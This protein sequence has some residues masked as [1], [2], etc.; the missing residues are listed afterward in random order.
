M[1]RRMIRLAIGNT[2]TDTWSYTP[3][4]GATTAL[5]LMDWSSVL[6]LGGGQDYPFPTV[7]GKPIKP[8]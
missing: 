3:Q 5:R 6:G 8:S 4:M 7:P 2:P 1:K